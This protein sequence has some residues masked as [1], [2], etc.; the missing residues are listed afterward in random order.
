MT[1]AFGGGAMSETAPPGHVYIIRHAEKPSNGSIGIDIEGD[2]DPHSLIPRGWQRSGAIGVLF[3][4]SALVPPDRLICPDYG[5]TT[6]VHRTYQTLLGLA[7]LTQQTI[8]SPFAEGSEGPLAAAVTAQ[9]S[10]TVLI[11]WEHHHIPDIAAG[12]RT[13]TAPPTQWPEDRFDLIWRF[14]LTN[15]DP[16]TYD[17]DVLPQHVLGGDPQTANPA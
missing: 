15:A 14:T 6:T 10:G 17:F 8:E 13:N 16:A 12:F 3:T 11:S 7:G 1:D 2:P 9:Y 4:G 5:A